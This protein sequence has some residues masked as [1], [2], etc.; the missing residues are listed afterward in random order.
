MQQAGVVLIIAD[1]DEY[2]ACGNHDY[3]GVCAGDNIVEHYSP[4]VPH[5]LHAAA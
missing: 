5:A 1:S 4:S 2:H 3:K